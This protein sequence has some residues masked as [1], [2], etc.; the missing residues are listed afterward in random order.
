MGRCQ[1][2]TV[3]GAGAAAYVGEGRGW[4]AAEEEEIDGVQTIQYVATPRGI[5]RDP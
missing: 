5:A 4:W 2:S 1:S 3:G